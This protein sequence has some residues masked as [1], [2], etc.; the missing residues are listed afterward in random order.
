[1]KNYSLIFK[2]CELFQNISDDEILR[3][4]SC[5]SAQTISY[6]KDEYI[7]SD[8]DDVTMIGIVLCGSVQIIKEDFWGNCSILSK[9][10]PGDLFCESF[11][12]AQ[13]KSIPVS[14]VACE[15]CDILFIDYSKIISTCSSACSYHNSLLQNMVKILASKNI[16]LTQ[17]IEHIS[18]KATREKLLSF[19]SAQAS[20]AKSNSFEIE[21][22]R[23]DLADYLSVD[24]SA[25]SKELC[26][27]RDEGILKFNKNEFELL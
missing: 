13:I 2:K 1:M 18:K 14:V 11:V 5:L 23:Q 20:K 16:M 7:V 24:R 26:K 6:K 10:M 19:L 9:G 17:K 21:F 12:C 4:L 22:N 25:M 27:L 15:K 3:L 8:S